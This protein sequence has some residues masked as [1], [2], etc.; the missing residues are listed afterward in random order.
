MR[1]YTKNTESAPIG[2][3]HPGIQNVWLAKIIVIA[4]DISSVGFSAFSVTQ[5]SLS[6]VLA[7]FDHSL[8][9]FI[10]KAPI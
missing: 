1:F 6:V 5:D 3:E 2:A 9:L 4:T 7:L 10:K 8:S